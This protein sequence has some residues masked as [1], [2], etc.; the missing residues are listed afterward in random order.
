MVK[1]SPKKEGKDE[2]VLTAP[3]QCPN[4]EMHHGC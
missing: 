2:A 3:K 1:A 4:V